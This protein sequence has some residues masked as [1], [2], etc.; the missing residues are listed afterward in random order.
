[1]A[2]PTQATIN[3][4]SLKDNYQLAKEHSQMAYA[5]IK[6][7]AYGHGAI[8]AAQALAKADGFAVACMD[9]AIELRHQGIKNP[10][11]VLEGAFDKNEWLAAVEHDIEMV[12]HH[13]SQLDILITEPCFTRIQLWLKIDTSMNRLGFKLTESATIFDQCRRADL[14]IKVLMSH[15]SC[16]DDLKNDKT[17]VQFK[18]LQDILNQQKNFWPELIL[19]S[20]NSAAIIAWPEVRDSISRPGIML[21]G[22][23]PLITNIESASSLKPVMTV[24]SKLIS[25]HHVNAGESVGYGESWIAEKATRVGIV[26]IGYGDGYPRSAPSGTPVWCNGKRLTTLGRVSM[27]MLCIDITDH[28][29]IDIGSTV[30]LWGENISANE[31]ADLCNTISYELFC[32]LTARV[33]RVY[34]K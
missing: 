21:Y 13:Q 31:I 29:D 8:P 19:S 34:E 25:S 2:R 32:Q 9:E 20:N 33:K 26:A 10:I 27:D 28:Q 12:V 22:S 17:R 4:Q 16:A 18:A 6:A 14:K 1:M 11:L 24:Q 3:L 23:S 30:E 5:V 7:N 15:F